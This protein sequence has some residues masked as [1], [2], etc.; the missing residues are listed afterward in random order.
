M[1]WTRLL[2]DRLLGE[3]SGSSDS[4][5]SAVSIH[6]AVRR[7]HLEWT[8]AREYFDSVSDPDLVEYAAYR[9]TAA[10]KIYMHLLKQCQRESE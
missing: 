2:K 7:A 4:D 9:V 6:E 5:A 8:C 3:E 1:G 10:E